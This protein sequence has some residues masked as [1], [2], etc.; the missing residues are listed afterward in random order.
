MPRGR[1]NSGTRGASRGG[2][3]KLIKSVNDIVAPKP[4]L[5]FNDNQSVNALPFGR[6]VT[7]KEI[8]IPS[9]GNKEPPAAPKAFK[10]KNY[11]QGF[12]LASPEDFLAQSWAGRSRNNALSDKKEN[13]TINQSLYQARKPQIMA[14]NTSGN[15]VRSIPANAAPSATSTDV[16]QSSEKPTVES[17]MDIGND[18]AHSTPV[19]VGNEFGG[20]VVMI[21]SGIVHIKTV[22]HNSQVPK[23]I[24]I[25]VLGKILLEEP[26][27]DS[28]ELKLDS[29][30]I[31]F[32]S[33]SKKRRTKWIL[34][35]SRPRIAADVV[36]ALERLKLQPT[37]NG[38][39]HASANDHDGEM[40]TFDEVESLISFADEDHTPQQA[41]SQFTED[42]FS[43]MGNQ[44]IEDAV[45][46]INVKVEQDATL[47]AGK[48]VLGTCE[49]EDNQKRQKTFHGL[50]TSRFAD[51]EVGDFFNRSHVFQKL[52]DSTADF[53]KKQVSKGVFVKT[54][55]DACN[56]EILEPVKQQPRQQYSVE[57]LMS[58]K[59]Q[60]SS[61]KNLSVLN[62]CVESSS[63]DEPRSLI[64]FPELARVVS[65]SLSLP[66]PETANPNNSRTTCLDAPIVS[67]HET[68]RKL[69][70][71]TSFKYASLQSEVVFR[72]SSKSKEPEPPASKP[73]QELPHLKIL[74]PLTP[75]PIRGL[76]TSKYASRDAGASFR[77]PLKTKKPE[78]STT[79]PT[80]GLS[81]PTDHPNHAVKAFQ[82]FLD[83][84]GH[85]TPSPIPF[86][87][88]SASNFPNHPVGMIY[89]GP[90]TSKFLDTPLAQPF[91]GLSTSNQSEPVPSERVQELSTPNDID[92]PAIKPYQ[93]L[94]SSK[95]A[96]PLAA[97][98]GATKTNGSILVQGVPKNPAI[99]AQLSTRNATVADAKREKITRTGIPTQEDSVPPSILSMIM[100][101]N[102][103][104]KKDSKAIDSKF[105]TGI[106]RNSEPLSPVSGSWNNLRRRDSFNSHV[107]RDSN[108]TVKPLM[109]IP[110]MKPVQD[111]A[112]SLRLSRTDSGH[113]SLSTDSSTSCESFATA[114][115]ETSTTGEALSESDR[116]LINENQP[117]YF[118]AGTSDFILFPG[119]VTRPETAEADLRIKSSYSS[120]MSELMG[121]SF[122][123]IPQ[124]DSSDAKSVPSFEPLNFP[125][126]PPRKSIAKING[127]LTSSRFATAAENISPGVVKLEP[128]PSSRIISNKNENGPTIEKLA[129]KPPVR[130]A[131]C[132][133]LPR[134]LKP[135][136]SQFTPSI[137]R[138]LIT[139]TRSLVPPVMSTFPPPLQP[140]MATVMVP[141]P[142]C[143][144]ILREVSGLLK[145][146]STPI[147]GY[148]AAQN[149]PMGGNFA[150]GVTPTNMLSLQKAPLSPI[151]QK[152]KNIMDKQQEVQ[153]RLARSLAQRRISESPSS[154]GFRFCA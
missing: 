94:A 39:V 52:P 41:V 66:T 123:S 106:G 107:S 81:S 126:A 12:A 138:G 77:G 104:K 151:L 110:I 143:P 149:S 50:A 44:F 141:D 37:R 116:E 51:V 62:P 103:S 135:T 46:A 136:A 95:Y 3:A 134:V 114:I 74:D 130:E 60:P 71:L 111:H 4:N 96:S 79:T 102:E 8:Y 34:T 86:Q 21:G 48:E 68:P 150:F 2:F 132:G 20:K 128:Q 9:R 54:Q 99:V 45:N 154:S 112:V 88:L 65:E 22:N 80:H 73:V 5:S 29:G 100:D 35:V 142:H 78:P 119:D 124:P 31:S 83:S 118:Q 137:S 122:A 84:R 14:N 42:L 15:E 139:P 108:E 55:K 58:L 61:A 6:Y 140:V 69:S 1:A 97:N 133:T 36:E 129:P 19:L 131:E 7:D 87:G 120:D 153:E 90:E 40:A 64:S 93:G 98:H 43:L 92:R 76:S 16:Q 10:P 38:P 72:E 121:D 17:L 109:P 152:S 89:Q 125:T 82:S 59:N 49:A 148:I 70:G 115:E 25:E 105:S 127:G 27:L 85:K 26:L 146:S 63:R 113:Q 13:L 67:G 23:I 91:E 11:N 145:M 18:T 144:G 57:K 28:L 30:T 33:D 101:S 75:K 117:I 24:Q 147:V 56:Q 32:F 53:I 47:V